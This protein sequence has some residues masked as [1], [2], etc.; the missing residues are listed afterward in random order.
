MK[1]S[2]PRNLQAIAARTDAGTDLWL[3]NLTGSGQRLILEGIG[4]DARIG[5]LDAESFVAAASDPDALV[6]PSTPVKGSSIELD[7]YAVAR[8]RA[9]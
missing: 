6:Q 7:A 4:A 5:Q 1:I 2:T 3:A 9:D 8:I